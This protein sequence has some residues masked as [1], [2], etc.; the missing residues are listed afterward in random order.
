MT[1]QNARKVLTKALATNDFETQLNEGLMKSEQAES[2]A[3]QALIWLAA[4]PD[5]IGGFLAASGASADEIRSLAGDL[6]FLGSVL[7]YL[8]MTDEGVLGFTEDHNMA[9]TI[10][11]EARAALPGGDIPNWT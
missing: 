4:D 8:L 7:D 2:I 5:Q 6:V 10:I 1:W 11:A 3:T 9:P